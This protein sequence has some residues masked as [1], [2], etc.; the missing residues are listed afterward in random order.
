MR[1]TIDRPRVVLGRGEKCDVA[2]PDPEVS[3]QHLAISLSESGASIEDLSG[4]GLL[5]AGK[6][7]TSGPLP[8]G[9]DIELGQWRAI[10][11]HKTS[12][13]D[14]AAATEIGQKT[15]VGQSRISEP[16]IS[17][18]LRVRGTKESVH[19]LQVDAFTIG[20]DGTND[21]VLN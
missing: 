20:K 4:K 9:A 10:F 1:F 17:A 11:R 16:A 7:V 19:K 13:V 18:Q 5:V 15:E 21:L 8:D 6:K 12:N 14:E 2:V 3:R